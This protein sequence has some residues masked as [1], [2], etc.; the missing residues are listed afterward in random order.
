MALIPSDVGI[1]MRLPG[2]SGLQPTA[3]ISDIPSDLPDLQPGNLFSARIQDVLPENTYR[4]LVAG[5][6]LTLALP[7]GAKPGDVLELVVIERTPRAIVARPA[8]DAATSEP[9]QHTSLS[10]TGQ[11]IGRLLSEQQTNT[12]TP[13][14][15]GNPLLPTAPTV[16]NTA[17]L[18]ANLKQGVEQSGLFYEAHQSQWVAGK[19]PLAA[20][21]QEPQGQWSK[22]EAMDHAVAEVRERLTGIPR[23]TTANTK[24]TPVE[25]EPRPAA[26]DTPVVNRNEARA[27]P[28]ELRP[29]VHQQLEAAASQ[30]M[31][32]HG[33]LWP[34]QVME[35]EVEEDR[36][37][38]A[39]SAEEPTP[40]LTTLRL[41]T[42]R[43][44]SVEARLRLSG[45]TLQ[46]NLS[47]PVGA[48]AADMRDEIPA[49]TEAL[50]AV[51]IELKAAQ[52]RH[53]PL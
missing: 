18:A 10:P 33:E 40:W 24:A 9:Y 14:N 7:E 13:L 12:S 42:P 45:N 5:R 31:L 8:P 15:R 41:T 17:Q 44:G 35:W 20:L 11:L 46:L 30:R 21:L 37:Q 52:I 51:G 27:L 49:L 23:E 1:R 47:T 38:P 32:W 3:P 48:S 34:G 39:A 43:L 29:L 19:R 25:N 28:E 6:S 2:D 53:E 36:Q 26:I 50:A 16:I 4:A 22:P